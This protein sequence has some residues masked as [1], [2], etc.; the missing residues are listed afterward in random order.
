M[1]RVLVIGSGVVGSSV[2]TF[3]HNFGVT[4]ITISEEA[5][6]VKTYHNL[7][8]VNT[9]ASYS[10]RGGL[11]NFWHNVIDLDSIDLKN[12][13]TDL[14]KI[15][16]LISNMAPDIILSRQELLPYTPIRPINL[17]KKL[18]EHLV[19][20]PKCI[21]LSKNSNSVTAT[22]EGGMVKVFDRVF[23]CNGAM[24][25]ADILI[26]SGMADRNE[27]VS[28]HIIFYEN[29]VNFI[30]RESREYLKI[31]RGE[32]YFSRPYKIIA[33]AKLTYRPVYPGSERRMLKN[34]AIYNDSKLRIALKLLNPANFMQPLESLYL[35]YGLLFPTNKY[36]RFVQVA[37]DRCYYWENQKLMVDAVQV[38]SAVKKLTSCGINVS[39]SSGV[40]GIHYH[41]TIQN[42]DDDVGGFNNKVDAK[43]QLLS[44]SYQFKP[45][46]HHFTFKLIV[47]SSDFKVSNSI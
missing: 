22:F 35:R 33:D 47:D 32:G 18:N 41:N 14:I 15:F 20:V 28:D 23:V 19:Y 10:G 46:P 45:G 17:L 43:I 42:L 27:T 21:L 16:Q 24:N 4:D 30:D 12:K 3:L 2:V 29:N 25:S 36:R 5:A 38:G 44:A 1:E 7:F 8:N 37:V 31:A 11:G 6:N 34:R 39:T 26:D 9:M 40:S 13:K